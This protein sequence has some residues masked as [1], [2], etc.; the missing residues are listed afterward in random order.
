MFLI[1]LQLM[2]LSIL[3]LPTAI[4]SLQI[5]LDLI[6]QLH[7]LLQSVTP[8]SLRFPQSLQFALDLII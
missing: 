4:L 8:L 7:P 5:L 2:V 1:S 6:L 3:P